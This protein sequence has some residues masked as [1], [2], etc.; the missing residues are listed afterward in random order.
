MAGQ[1]SEKI[2]NISFRLSS[3][4]KM[5]MIAANSFFINLDSKSLCGSERDLPDYFFMP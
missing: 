4:Q 2:L 3:D 5:Q 1:Y